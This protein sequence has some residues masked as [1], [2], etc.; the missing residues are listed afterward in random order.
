MGDGAI[1][2]HHLG[3]V[4]SHCLCKLMAEMWAYELGEM[5]ILAVLKGFFSNENPVKMSSV[6]TIF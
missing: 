2:A 3:G 6:S 4:C 5:M 1:R